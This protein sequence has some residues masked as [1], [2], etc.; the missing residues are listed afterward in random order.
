MA[1]LFKNSSFNV[2]PAML[3]AWLELKL[4]AVPNSTES[5][6]VN[7]NTPSSK[8]A[9][10]RKRNLDPVTREL[11]AAAGERGNKG[12]MHGRVLEQIFVS[13]ARVIKKCPASP[14]MP[15]VLRGIAKFAHQ[16]NVSLLLDVLSNLRAMLRSDSG[17]RTATLTLT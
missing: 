9:K 10:K 8:N 5:E 14:L 11:A 7:S 4:D 13:Y 15:L 16:V 1:E 12:L 2:H 6:G 3:E 17:T